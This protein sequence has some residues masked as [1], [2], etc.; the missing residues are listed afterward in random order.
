M[1]DVRDCIDPAIKKSGIKKFIVAE[2]AGLTQQ[3]LCDIIGKRRKLDSNELMSIC[4]AI[5]MTPNELVGYGTKAKEV[6]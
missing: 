6:G 1:S 5:G 3:Q 2:R 4:E